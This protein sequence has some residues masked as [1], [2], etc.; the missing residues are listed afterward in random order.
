MK[1]LSLTAA[2]LA[3]L[4]AAAPIKDDTISGKI[5]DWPA[6]KTGE[7]RLTY[8][9]TDILADP[10]VVASAPVDAQGNFSLKLPAQ[11]A[12]EALL[13]KDGSML[14]IR[15]PCGGSSFGCPQLTSLEPAG[16]VGFFDLMAFANKDDQAKESLGQVFFRNS[17]LRYYSSGWSEGTLV[18]STGN[19]A[20]SADLVTGPAD[21]LDHQVWD[22]KLSNGWQWLRKQ[23]QELNKESGLWEVKVTADNLSEKVF[24]FLNE[25]YGG[26]GLSIEDSE[27]GVTVI[28][29][30]PGSG[31]EKAGI[32]Y[33]DTIVAVAGKSVQN[34]TASGVGPML[35]GE[36][37][38]TVTLTIKRGDQTLTIPVTHMYFAIPK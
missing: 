13:P 28:K 14:Q 27:R 34:V 18:Y 3:S 24:F 30:L 37:G 4:V 23:A 2:L 21:M 10:A 32:Q 22:V 19:T 33:G 35:R 26:T 5:T 36:P 38:S 16:R 15:T 9:N 31:A 1:K 6:G 11:A 20:L 7:V 8:R 12:V 17:A 29:I 25:G